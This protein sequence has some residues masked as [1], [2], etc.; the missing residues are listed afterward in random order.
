MDDYSEDW[1][2]LSYGEDDDLTAYGVPEAS[3]FP[4]SG[5]GKKGKKGSKK[6]DRNQALAAA[7]ANMMEDS[8]YDSL[9]EDLGNATMTKGGKKKAK[10]NKRAKKDEGVGT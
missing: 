4:S 9:D 1:G 3:D 8:F 7:Q 10:K 2:S 5:R 6:K